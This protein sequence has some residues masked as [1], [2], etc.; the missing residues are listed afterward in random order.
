MRPMNSLRTIP[1]LC[2][3]AVAALGGE[4]IYQYDSL[5]RLTNT[6]YSQGVVATYKY[7]SAHNIR[8]VKLIKDT[9]G[10]GLPDYWEMLYFG[11]LTATDGTKDSDG[12]GMSDYDEYLAGTDPTDR[13]SNMSFTGG[14]G[15]GGGGGSNGPTLFTISWSSATNRDYTIQWST[16][17]M[18][19]FTVLVTNIP[20]TPPRNQYQHETMATNAFYRVILQ[21]D[22]VSETSTNEVAP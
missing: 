16:D 6:A 14:W 15:G 13:N 5:N 9:D 21:D 18:T 20:G 19:N 3:L 4:I 2:L 17:L 22:V 7:D 1:C 11:S 12:D 10:D 8:E